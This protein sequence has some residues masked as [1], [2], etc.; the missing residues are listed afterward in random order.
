MDT[1]G[2]IFAVLGLIA[3]VMFAELASA[4]LPMLI[5]I[6]FVSPSD[7]RDLA[8]VLAAADSSRRLR[9]VRTSSRSCCTPCGAGRRSDISLFRMRGGP[10][11]PES[12]T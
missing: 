1:V 12:G 8:A 11:G 3:V 2:L 5:V 10:S 7:R 9:V 4:V 6:G